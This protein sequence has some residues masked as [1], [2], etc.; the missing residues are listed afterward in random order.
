[1]T[2]M[3]PASAPV[4]APSRTRLPRR[5]RVSSA[6]ANASRVIPSRMVKN[7]FT[8]HS[9]QRTASAAANRDALSLRQRMRPGVDSTLEGDA[10]H[11]HVDGDEGDGGGSGCV[12]DAHEGGS[13]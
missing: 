10:V 9:S 1:M 3:P 4:T 7:E 11:G 2:R 13:D 12:A 8:P 5:A 6:A